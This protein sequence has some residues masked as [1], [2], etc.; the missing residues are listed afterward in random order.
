MHLLATTATNLDSAEP[1]CALSR[2]AAR[3][4]LSLSKLRYLYSCSDVGGS[5]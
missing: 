1:P 2:H 4:G 3:R 5:P